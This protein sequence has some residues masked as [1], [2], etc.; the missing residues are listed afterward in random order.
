MQRARHLGGIAFEQYSI[1][2]LFDQVRAKKRFKKKLRR[3]DLS[4]VIIVQLIR[5]SVGATC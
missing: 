4:I 1:N 2:R 5:S 3:S